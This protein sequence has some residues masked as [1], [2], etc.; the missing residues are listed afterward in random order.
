[1][2]AV[3]N[4]FADLLL[5][6]EDYTVMKTIRLSLPEFKVARDQFEAN[7]ENMQFILREYGGTA[8]QLDSAPEFVEI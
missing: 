6:V 1:M 3:S 2:P 7:P 5:F 8:P 4:I